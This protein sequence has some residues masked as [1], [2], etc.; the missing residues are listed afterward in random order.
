MQA[1][2]FS[3]AVLYS[4]IHRANLLQIAVSLAFSPVS[5]IR[6]PSQIRSENKILTLNTVNA[7]NNQDAWVDV[8]SQRQESW[9][10]FLD[11]HFSIQS[12]VGV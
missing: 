11:K 8:H 6:F 2:V 9:K 3:D 1:P 12:R 7:P 10:N 4:V 5:Y